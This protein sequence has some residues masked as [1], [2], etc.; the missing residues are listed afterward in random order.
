MV[1]PIIWLM[2]SYDLNQ[3]CITV[4]EV[5]KVPAALLIHVPVEVLTKFFLKSVCGVEKI[6]N[7]L[8]F[9]VWKS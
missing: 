3:L 5:M 2:K 9:F 6:S 8:I 7:I 1:K 4:A